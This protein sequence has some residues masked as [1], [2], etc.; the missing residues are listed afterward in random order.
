MGGGWGA[1]WV[2][3]WC[4]RSV[5]LSLL[6]VRS[7]AGLPIG[8]A[9]RSCALVGGFGLSMVLG[10]GVVSIELHD[11]EWVVETQI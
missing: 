11:C 1:P 7:V 8:I 6:R 3:F 10:F 4:C 2:R 5:G 9:D